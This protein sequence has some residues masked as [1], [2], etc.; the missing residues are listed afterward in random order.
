MNPRIKLF[1]I[2]INFVLCLSLIFSVTFPLSAA[3]TSPVEQN[4]FLKVIGNQLCNQKGKPIQLRG[5]SSHGLQWYFSSKYVNENCLK[6]L[7]DNWNINLFRL[8]M[9]TREGGYIDD[10]EVVAIV[11]KGV[12]A[13]IKL[14]IYIIIDWHVLSEKDPNVYRNEA[15]NFFKEMASLYG[16]Y[17]N[18]LYEICNE[19]NGEDSWTIR[20]KPYAEAVIPAIRSI[21]RKNII[22]VGTPTWSQDVDV[23]ADN[24]LSGK[25]LMYACHF[26][27]GTHGEYLREKITYARQ[28]GLAIF[29]TEW[30]ATN[31][32]GN[33]PIYRTETQEWIDFLNK[34]KISWCNWNLSDKYENSAA[35]VMD[36]DENGNW[37]DEDLT[38]SGKLVK[39]LLNVNLDY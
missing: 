34:N 39:S 30:G 16:K 22:I 21:D 2:I 1:N 10:P 17:P 9:Y 33:G 38:D 32:S 15:I 28:K 26:Y 31:S 35:L 7:R 11:K 36:A 37:S 18:I 6:Y 8:A 13:A 12:E 25:N 14:D 27:A 29:V 24:P 4:G 3:E 5:I 19:P 20:I 23:V